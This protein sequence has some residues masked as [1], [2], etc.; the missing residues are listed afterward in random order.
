[1]HLH[2]TERDTAEPPRRRDPVYAVVTRMLAFALAP[3]AAV[4]TPGRGRHT[5]CRWA[6]AAR[7]PAECLDGL[8]P[9]ARAAF[10]AARTRALWEHG[11]LLGLTSGYRDPAAQGEIFR[12]EVRRCGSVTEA[13]R[14]ALPPEESRHVAGT[15]VDVRPTEGA[16]WLERHGALH[17]L[18]RVYDNEWWHFEHHPDGPPPRL[19]HPGAAPRGTVY[20]SIHAAPRPDRFRRAGRMA[21][22]GLTCSAP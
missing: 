19:P 20:R 2:D 18:Y 17:S 5:A 12:A 13:R 11:V 16:K 3:M 6:L 4:L 22:P 14:W 9:G 8:A 7:F 15:A 10:E 21:D 1:M